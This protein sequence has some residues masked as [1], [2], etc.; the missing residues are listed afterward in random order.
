MITVSP[1]LIAAISSQKHPA[2]APEEVGAAN[3]IW[4]LLGVSRPVMVQ[5]DVA[6]YMLSLAPIAVIQL[7]GFILGV[8]LFGCLFRRQWMQRR[9]DSAG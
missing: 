4:Q 9:R 7:E 6:V 1:Q 5:T 3:E 2:G 8:F